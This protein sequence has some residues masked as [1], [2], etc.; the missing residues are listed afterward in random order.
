MPEPSNITVMLIEDSALDARVIE[1]A[2]GEAVDVHFQLE[3][4]KRL[5][6]GLDRLSRNR[7]DVLLLD[8]NL[9]DSVGTQTVVA[10]RSRFPHLPIVVLTGTDERDV[11]LEAINVG[12]QDYLPKR[13]MDSELLTRSLLY[14][15]QRRQ[16]EDTNRELAAA[17]EIQDRLSPSSSPSIAGFDIAGICH[18][19]SVAGGDYFDYVQLHDGA[20]GILVADVSGHGLGPAMLMG[21]VRASI[22][23]LASANMKPTQILTAVNKSLCKDT[24]DDKFIT[25]FFLYLDPQ[26]RT[27]RHIG[28]GHEAHLLRGGTELL[29]LSANTIPLTMSERMDCRLT[30]PLGIS[31]G[32]IILLMTDGITEAPNVEKEQFGIDRTLDVVRANASRSASEIV[33]ALYKAT[34]KFVGNDNHIDDATVVI[35]KVMA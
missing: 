13:R 7:I 34:L 26:H 25:L 5:D 12:A 11:G 15:I 28:A 4:A 17:R 9:P 27:I 33:D 21:E 18:P 23:A 24:P 35:I 29:L 22:R 30:E 2:L 8:L 3:R 16:V 20:W 1:K 31:A 10:A 19:A 14:A 6:V 32:D